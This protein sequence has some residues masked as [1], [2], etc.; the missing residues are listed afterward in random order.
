MGAHV[1][2]QLHRV[3]TVVQ[4]AVCS[5]QFSSPSQS[6]TVWSPVSLKP[7]E[8]MYFKLKQKQKQAL[9]CHQVELLH[10]VQLAYNLK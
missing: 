5:D 2:Q 4:Q 1:L 10:S 7:L 6:N 9:T 3:D 8:S